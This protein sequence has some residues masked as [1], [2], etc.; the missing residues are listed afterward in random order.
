[1]PA[2]QAGKGYLE[3]AKQIWS[4]FRLVLAAAGWMLEWVYMK[5]LPVRWL[6]F[7]ASLQGRLDYLLDREK[8]LR[9]QRMARS[10]GL[11]ENDHDIRRRLP[12]HYIYFRVLQVFEMLINI[13]R[14][15]F[16]KSVPVEGLEHLRHALEAGRST[17]L[18]TAHFGY[19]RLIKYLLHTRG[20]QVLM[21]KSRAHHQVNKER[22]RV[23][24]YPPIIQ[25]LHRKFYI[26]RAVTGSREADS[27]NADFN[28]RPVMRLLQKP[29]VLLVLGD[30]LRALNF[31]EVPFLGYTLPLPTGIMSI[32]LSTHA[33]ACP[34]FVVDQ[35]NPRHP[36][37]I[38]Y[39]P[40]E[41]E[42]TGAGLEDARNNMRK[43]G[44]IFEQT[45]REYPHLY[46]AWAIEHF[47]D[48]RLRRS[49][50]SLD[51]RYKA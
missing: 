6:V 22:R 10:L 34:A 36:R 20:I 37:L 13:D 26:S 45:V 40:L 18:L 48:K 2:F 3:Q 47:F 27:V 50:A 33:V 9:R 41:L 29:S 14:T 7:V 24:Q 8:H 51:R 38:I 15:G 12:Q 39:P 42:K 5:T 17:I 49:R 21:I 31:V 44:R 46:K 35:G 11:P 30:G 28:V 19:A 43:F 32:A 16:L 23:K 1:M 4:R 25:R